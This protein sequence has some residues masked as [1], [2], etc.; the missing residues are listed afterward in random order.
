MGPRLPLPACAVTEVQEDCPEFPRESPSSTTSPVRE[1]S[2]T[3]A[4][5]VSLLFEHRTAAFLLVSAEKGL[6]CF[7]INPY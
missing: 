2:C 3:R 1:P 6:T 7:R 4:V 5:A